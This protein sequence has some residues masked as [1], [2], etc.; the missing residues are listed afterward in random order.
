MPITLGTGN[1]ASTTYI[2]HKHEHTDWLS[3]SIEQHYSKG[4][5]AYSNLLDQYC[6]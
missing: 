5:A 6:K 1:R 2:V 3:N 4:F